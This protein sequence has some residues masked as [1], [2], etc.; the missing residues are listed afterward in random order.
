MQYKLHG[1]THLFDGSGGRLSLSYLNPDIFIFLAIYL[2]F[3]FFNICSL[4]ILIKSK[5][6]P[7][8]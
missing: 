6:Q 3:F 2:S 8:R 4:S 1:K 5:T 7:G